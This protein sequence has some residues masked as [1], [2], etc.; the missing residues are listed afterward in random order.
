MH[1]DIAHLV[2]LVD[3][4]KFDDGTLVFQGCCIGFGS[5]GC[6]RR[7][8]YVEFL[9]LA[10]KGDGTESTTSRLKPQTD[11]GPSHLCLEAGCYLTTSAA[12]ADAAG[13][14]ARP[15]K[16]RCALSA[17]GPRRPSPVLRGDD[18]ITFF[19]LALRDFSADAIRNPEPDAAHLGFTI[20]P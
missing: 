20:W 3:V 12:A 2:N 18:G 10:R 13:A 6:I 14:T 9:K 7:V 5:L 17:A 15:A 4:I 1:F 16:T 11:S 8:H 19:Q